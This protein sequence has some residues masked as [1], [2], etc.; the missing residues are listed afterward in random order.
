MRDM[1]H[2]MMPFD[3]DQEFEL[4]YD[5]AR[6]YKDLPQKTMIKVAG[7][8]ELDASDELKIERNQK[9]ATAKVKGVDGEVSSD[10]WEDVDV[11][12]GEIE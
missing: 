11:D 7:E 10:D 12:D 5:F 9:L 3:K 6:A 2:C 8:E 4:F 1:G